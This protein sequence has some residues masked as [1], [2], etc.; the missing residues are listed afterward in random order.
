MDRRIR[1]AFSIPLRRSDIVSRWYSGDEIVILFDS[2]SDEEG[3]ARKL[4]D[5]EESATR[6]DI[7]F[8]HEVGTWDVGRESIVAL[9]DRLAERNRKR[10]LRRSEKERKGDGDG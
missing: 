1:A 8:Q 2:D 7:S 10:A 3:A 4:S 5:L 6:W 9:V